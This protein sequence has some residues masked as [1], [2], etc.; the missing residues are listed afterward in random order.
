[1]EVYGD[2]E[3]GPWVWEAG[4]TEPLQRAL[5]GM[6]I[7]R[8]YRFQHDAYKAITSGRDTVIVSGTGTGKTEAFLAPI[9]DMIIREGPAAPRP[10]ALIL[11]PTKALA[12]DQLYRFKVLA[13]GRL[14]IRVAVLDGDTPRAERTSIYSSP[15]HIIVSNPDMLHMGLAFSDKFR[16]LVSKAKFIVV[17]E[18]HVYRGVFGSHVRKVLYRAERTSGRVVF[19]GSGATIGNPASMGE[20]LFA[21]SVEVVE[22]PKR[23]KGTAIH[24]LADYGYGSRW[25]TAAAIISLLVRRGLKVLGF[26]DSQQM[27]ELIARISLKSYGVRVGVHRAGLLPEDRRRVEEDFREGRINAVVSTPTME[28]GI[29]L[30]DLDAVVMAHLPRSISSYIQRSGR[31]G[32]RDEPGLVITLLGDDP[33]EAYFLQH[34]QELFRM[35]PDPG[36]IEPG[37]RE[38]AKVHLAA[39]LLQ[40][41]LVDID[42]IPEDLRIALEDLEAMRIAVRLN[43]KVAPRWG[44][45][46]SYVEAH[47]SL[48]SSGPQVRIVEDGRE[49][50]KREMPMAL[51]DL[52]PGAVYY[53]SGRTYV[54]LKLDIESMR[55]DVRR[56]GADL[57]FYTKPMYSIDVVSITPLEERTLGPLRIVYGDIKIMVTVEGYYV[58]DEYSGVT[59]SEVSYKDPIKWEYWTKGIATRYPNPGITDQ[60]ALLSGYHALEHTIIAA[61]RPVVG[62]SDTDLGG[63]SYPSGHIV[64]YDS[65]PGGHGASKLVFER[66]ER[67]HD[68]AENILASCTCEDGCP[69]CVFSPYCGVNNKFLS[70]KTALKILV[71][72]MKTSE[73]PSKRLEPPHGTPYA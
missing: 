71:Y 36:Y 48:R 30:G 3:P 59:L 17:D 15:P 39:L 57:N 24:L 62:A 66:L 37:N 2:P 65:A 10:Y 49:I 31:A 13:E 60:V 16:R 26:V 63:V 53:H 28:L 29:D 73:R 61:A 25:S 67:V 6:G 70:R 22:G 7:E 52:Y 58:K 47:G 9:L 11:Y 54:S 44:R 72:T 41:G 38:I 56:V 33:I 35:E 43:G 8:L 45:A 34:P 50:G 18:M 1:M 23:R 5:R 21:R 40:T 12:R 46:R 42:S 32:R 69:K 68:I 4:L 51:Y 27:A 14:G 19:I 55:A 20:K 64:I